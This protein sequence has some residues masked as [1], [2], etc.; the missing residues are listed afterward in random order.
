MAVGKLLLGPRKKMMNLSNK[1]TIVVPCKNEE[2]YIHHLL[3]ALR[4]QNIGNTRIIIADC[5]T[6]NTR[7]VIRDNS[8]LLNV[9]IIEG[10]P[11]SFAKNSGAKLVTT[12]YILFIDADVRFFKPTVIKD[13]VNKMESK[14]LD[15]VGLNIKSYD[16]D[17][18]AIIGFTLFNIINHILKFFSPFAIGAFMLTRR[19]KF[20]EFGGFPE[21]T[22]TSEDYFLSRMYSPKKFRILNHYFGQDSRRFKKMGYFGMGY[23]LIRNFMNRNNKAYW[24]N[25]DSSKYWN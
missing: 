16:K 6:D 18:R 8:S 23:Y 11:V 19:D 25:L 15:L 10:G 21:K 20:E 2:N 3:D 14:N 22:V 4:L 5:S 9:E 13:A 12:P 7:Q 17:I 24:D 1:I